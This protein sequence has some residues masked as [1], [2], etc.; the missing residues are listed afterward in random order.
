MENEKLIRNNLNQYLRN[1][2]QRNVELQL[3]NRELFLIASA[4]QF[5]NE[6]NN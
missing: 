3:D 5:L 6:P 2:L 1:L 4:I